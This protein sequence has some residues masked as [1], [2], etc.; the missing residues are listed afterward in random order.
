MADRHDMESAVLDVEGAMALFS[1]AR[2]ALPRHDGQKWADVG[3]VPQPGMCVALFA[4]GEWRA[5]DHAA[6]VLQ[7]AVDKLSL[8][9]YGPR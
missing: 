3:V 7:D 9:F 2:E 6:T 4:E 5:F 8:A 1:V